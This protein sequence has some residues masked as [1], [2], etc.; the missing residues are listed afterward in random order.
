MSGKVIEPHE[1]GNF[2]VH[3]RPDIHSGQSHIYT[4]GQMFI[5]FSF[6]LYAIKTTGRECFGISWIRN[7]V[8]LLLFDFVK[9]NI[10]PANHYSF[11]LIITHFSPFNWNLW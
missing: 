6:L 5:D 1:I 2:L 9:Y 10:R 11:R 7:D 3:D 4:P 8:I